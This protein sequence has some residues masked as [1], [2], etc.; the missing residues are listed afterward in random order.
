MN[1]DSVKAAVEAAISTNDF[2]ENLQK[3]D[4]TDFKA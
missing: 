4:L 3:L 2:K 1:M